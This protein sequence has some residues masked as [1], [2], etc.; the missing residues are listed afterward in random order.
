[1]EDKMKNLKKFLIAGALAA[2]VSMPS[3]SEAKVRVYVRVGPPKVTRVSVVKVAKPYRNAIWVKGH[4]KFVSGGYRW[5]MGHY[6][7]GRRHY[8]YVQPRWIKTRRG[9][10]FIAGRWVRKC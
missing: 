1:M 4:Y 7:N 6:I 9:H 3:L 5:V 2:I 10:R 8:V